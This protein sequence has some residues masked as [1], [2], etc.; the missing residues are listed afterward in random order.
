MQIR[1][2]QAADFPSI[3]ALNHESVRF[4]S[5]LDHPRLA[6][7]HAQAELHLVVEDDAS[8]VVA[9]LLALREGA[10]YDSPNYQWFAGR[11]PRF[12]Y[13][14]RI[15]VGEHHHG[16]GAG[17]LLYQHVF[18]HARLIGA[19]VVACEI[20]VEPPNPVSERFHAKRG[21]REMGRQAV[22]SGTKLVSLQV[23]VL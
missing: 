5:P 11:Y 3:L 1:P 6:A 13:V 20:D 21:F 4:L 17:K 19:E 15:V 8:R 18:D 22:A 16:A 23:A 14:D 10:A 12:L 2:T 9:F 7:L